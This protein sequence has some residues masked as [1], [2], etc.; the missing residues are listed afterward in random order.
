MAG[1]L[2]CSSG[3]EGDGS[4]SA[5]GAGTESTVVTLVAAPVTTSAPTSTAND[6]IRSPSTTTDL[7]FGDVCGRVI[8]EA[9]TRPRL[10]RVSH[11]RGRDARL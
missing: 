7:T 2:A 9:E 3:G 4:T 1:V 5:P 10:H 6:S 8:L 11:S